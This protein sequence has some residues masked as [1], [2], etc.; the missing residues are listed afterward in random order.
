MDIDTRTGCIRKFYEIYPLSRKM[1][2]DT[3][4]QKKYHV[5]RTQQIVLLS[6]SVCGE[7]NMTQL[8]SKIN[9]S[10]EQATRAVAQLVDLG[11]VQRKYRPENR[12]VV[13]IMLTPDAEVFLEKMKADIHDDLLNRFKN[14]SDEDMR[15]LYDSLAQVISVLKQVADT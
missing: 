8:A 5:T 14:V 6:L 11:F 7:M 4:D 3:F 12:R 13:N 1:V 9:T 10:N 2:F 15:K